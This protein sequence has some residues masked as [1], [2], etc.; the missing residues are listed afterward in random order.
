MPGKA[1][2]RKYLGNALQQRQEQQR[3]RPTS[4]AKTSGGGIGGQQSGSTGPQRQGVTVQFQPDSSDRHD[5]F[6]SQMTLHDTPE[7]AFVA[8]DA[9]HPA[10]TL[11]EVREALDAYFAPL[12]RHGEPLTPA[13]EAALDLLDQLASDLA[14]RITDP[15]SVHALIDRLPDLGTGC[16]RAVTA[17]L[18][19]AQ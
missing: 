2:D 12:P 1:K 19:E 3:D 18:R 4:T 7:Q 14:H 5:R 11:P 13:Q 15:A 9:Q 16:G 10:P 6:A 8:Y 17:A